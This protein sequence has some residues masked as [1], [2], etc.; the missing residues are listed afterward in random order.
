M[1]YVDA[2]KIG[3]VVHVVERV[4]GQRIFKKTPVLYRLYLKSKKGEY[5]S[6][7]GDK[8]AKF[9]TNTYKEFQKEKQGI[10]EF[11]LFEDDYDAITR[12]LEDNY[13]GAESPKLNIG[14]LDIEVDFD[15]KRGFSSPED[16][17][18][19][20]TAITVY[21][22]WTKKLLTYV[23]GPNTMTY[24]EAKKVAE[25]FP[26][27][28]L[29]KTEDE[30]FDRFFEAIDDADVLTGW[31]S[32]TF[33]IP[34]I[35]KRIELVSKKEKTKRFCLW[36]QYP[37]ERRFE[38][39]GKTQLT[40]DLVGRIHLD[41]LDLYKKYTYNELHSYSLDNVGE[42]EVKERKTAYEGSLDQLYKR[43]FKTFI[44]YNRQD[45]MLIVKIDAK[46]RSIK[47]SLYFKGSFHFIC[48]N[49]SSLTPKV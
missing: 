46:N 13:L 38:M 8:L 33:D 23:L 34:Y 26:D 4:D 11:N 45:V 27:T 30:L 12:H 40:F 20:I 7:H 21:Q 25:D 6:M 35:I 32:T 37:S 42:V 41:Y 17:H 49:F 3:D 2:V 19:K 14:F 18:G 31:N 5:T 29:C 36:N 44:E 15:P 47:N 1:S 16:P 43:D 48:S 28:V 39:Y 22:N 9:E 24:A 10:S